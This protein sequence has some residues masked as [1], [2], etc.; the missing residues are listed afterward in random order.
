MPGDLGL[1]PVFHY[2]EDA[3]PEATS[4]SAGSPC[5]SSWSGENTTG[6]TWRNIAH[7]LDRMHLVTLATPQGR[8]A[9]RST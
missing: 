3:H 9:R 5:W 8:V 4:N 2:C 7:E 6:D 1:R